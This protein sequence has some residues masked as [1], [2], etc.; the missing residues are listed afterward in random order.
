MT[1]ALNPWREFFNHN[2][3]VYE[4]EDRKLTIFTNVFLISVSLICDN[5]NSWPANTHVTKTKASN[6][7]PALS[8]WMIFADAYTVPE[9]GCRIDAP[10][11]PMVAHLELSKATADLF[12]RCALAVIL[13]D[14]I[15]EPDVSTIACP[16]S[17]TTTTDVGHRFGSINCLPE[18]AYNEMRVAETKNS[19]IHVIIKSYSSC[20]LHLIGRQLSRE[21]LE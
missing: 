5:I 20:L 16:T 17:I 12:P 21:S 11:F 14:T 9:C 7:F 19:S 10:Q 6:S 2:Q 3:R 15:T 8:G 4:S 18:P 1:E 13:R